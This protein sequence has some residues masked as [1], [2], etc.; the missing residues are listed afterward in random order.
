MGEGIVM[1][2]NSIF[3]EVGRAQLVS[4]WSLELEVPDSIL[5]D[6][7]ISFNFLMIRVLAIALNA[8]YPYNG[9]LTEEGG[10]GCT[11]LSL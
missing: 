11:S 4:V 9:A 7:N 8:L 6:S 1:Y 5:G 2:C 3:L 10:K